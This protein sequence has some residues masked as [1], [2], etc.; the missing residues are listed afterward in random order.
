MRLIRCLDISDPARICIIKPSALGDIVHAMPILAPIRERWPA[1][2]IAWVVNRPF[3]ELVETHK[4]VDEAIVYDAR[5]KGKS[6]PGVE[7][8][9]SLL[10]RLSRNPFDLTIDLQG[11]LRSAIMTAATRAKTRVGLADAREGARYFYTHHVDAPR[12]GIHAVDRTLRIAAALGANGSEA[13]FHVGISS[14]DRAWAQAV[15]AGLPSPRVILNLGAQWQTKRWPPGHFAEI[16]RRA[17]QEHGASLI[18]VGSAGDQSLIAELALQLGPIPLLNLCGKTRLSQLAALSLEADLVISNDT[19]PLHL[20][21]AAGARV[22]GIY[23]CTDPK[24]TGPYG[25][26][27]STVQSCVWCAPSFIKT[28][29]RLDCMTELSPDRV[30]PAVN[31]ELDGLGAFRSAS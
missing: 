30:W 6:S 20:A 4:E 8:S 28:C 27:V 24:L 29:K 19:G 1:S 31:R 16:G 14:D 25:P 9:V 10:R 17:V 13:R 2:H 11:L 3:R 12:R 22:L 15:V 23:T 18:A 26:R 21:A 7:G 5:P